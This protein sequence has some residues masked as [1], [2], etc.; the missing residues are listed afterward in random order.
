MDMQMK[1]V[2]YW[3]KRISPFFALIDLQT[4]WYQKLWAVCRFCGLEIAMVL[5]IIAILAIAIY[6]AVVAVKEAL[7]GM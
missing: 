7:A 3:Q 5:L 6:M 1:V 2:Q 4:T